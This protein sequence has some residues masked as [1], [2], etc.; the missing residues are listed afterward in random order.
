MMSVNEDDIKG[1]VGELL[2]IQQNLTRWV[3]SIHLMTGPDRL[4]MAETVIE[5]KSAS[6]RDVPVTAVYFIGDIEAA[7]HVLVE[8]LKG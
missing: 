6:G 2:S 8:R 5:V 1:F 3:N 4:E 7:C